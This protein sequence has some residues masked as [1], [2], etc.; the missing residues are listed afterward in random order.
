MALH[1]PSEPR[2]YILP[3]YY[4]VPFSAEE[5]EKV[6]GREEKAKTSVMAF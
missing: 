5:R 1:V 6:R 4:F 2:S 3:N